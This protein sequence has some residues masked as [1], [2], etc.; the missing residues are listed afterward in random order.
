MIDKTISNCRIIEKL[1]QAGTTPVESLVRRMVRQPKEQD[2]PL[3]VVR[4]NGSRFID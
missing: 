4:A 2:A 1:G 3:R